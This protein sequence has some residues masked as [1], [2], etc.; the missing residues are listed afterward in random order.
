[1]VAS[2]LCQKCGDVMYWDGIEETTLM[3]HFSPY[4]HNH[5]DN[6]RVRYYVCNCGYREAVSILNRCPACSWHGAIDCVYGAKVK[7]WPA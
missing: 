7:E 2:K 3:G 6:C 5:D 4:G 1:M